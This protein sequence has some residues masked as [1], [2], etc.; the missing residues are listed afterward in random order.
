MDWRAHFASGLPGVSKA[1]VAVSG[2]RDSVAL[3]HLL[4]RFSALNLAVA[5]LD[6]GLRDTSGED[7]AFVADLA[8]SL[9]L[10]FVSERVE[11]AGIAEKRGWSLEDAARRVRY[12]F[13]ARTAKRLSCDAI[14]TAHTVEDNAETVLLQLL[15]G[16]GRATGIPARRGFVL[17]PL[18]DVSKR[19]LE[20]FLLA[21]QFQ[22]REDASN[23]DERFTR[24]W[25]RH[26]VL[27]ILETRFPGA[28]VALGRYAE[29]SSAENEFLEDWTRAV[30]E[31][32]DWRLEHPVIQRRL[33]R[34]ALENANLRVDFEH[35]EA[36]RLALS[37]SHVTRVSLPG[38]A[39]GVV[40]GGRLR[41]FKDAQ[42]SVK[43]EWP[44]QFDFSA[45]P[46]AKLRTRA[47]GDRIRLPGG[48][49][50]LSD[51]LI[52]RKVPRELRDSIALVAQNNEVLWVGLEPPI[53]DLRI[54]ITKDA[55]LEAMR[56]ALEL[57]EEALRAGEVPVGAVVIQKTQTGFAGFSMEDQPKFKLH[58]SLEFEPVGRGR[59]RSKA[60]GDMTRHAELE[61]IREAAKTLGTPYLTHCTLVVTLEPCAMC[62]GAALEARIGRIV[63][64]ARNPK[65]GALGGVMDISRGAWNH[66]LQIRGGVLE[67]PSARLLT[68]FFDEV[69]KAQRVEG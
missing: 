62:L 13:L 48:T 4:A 22:W 64:G 67:G 11:V 39:T 6:H 25:L 44:A 31:G 28:A 53:T 54:G 20:A 55:E 58:S 46:M 3:L 15:Q 61:A 59:N 10:E 42:E 40:Q 68:A 38:A 56:G 35:L 14:L 17:R 9:E 43:P 7:A 45:F 23:T 50:K 5:H 63:Y 18:L 66:R 19:D 2:G 60:A 29:I 8:S 24:N 52:D 12:E 57:A 16:T 21:N 1:L 41:V 51:V 34:H 47:S 65:N 69:R 49:R 27:P 36:L 30:P 32:F 33:V 26:S 37:N